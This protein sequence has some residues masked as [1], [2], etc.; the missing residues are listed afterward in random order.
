MTQASLFEGGIRTPGILEWP[1]VIKQHRETWRPAYVSDYLP[2]VLELLGVEHPNPTWYKDGESLMPLVMNNDFAADGVT[3][4]SSW[5]RNTSLVFQLGNQAAFFS[6]NGTY[7][8]VANP[9]AGQCKMEKSTY[10]DSKTLHSPYLFNID[11]DP[12][13]T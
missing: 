8:I 4:G 2:T 3:V 11:E 12:T 1:A 7:K 13:E 10:L 6:P 9:E 5:E